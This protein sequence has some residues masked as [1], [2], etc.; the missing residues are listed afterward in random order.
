MTVTAT[1]SRIT[2]AGNGSTTT[3]AVPYY[4]LSN[5]DLALIKTTAAGVQTAL[6]LT[7]DYSVTGAGVLSG[8]SVTLVAAPAATETLIIYRDPSVT[9]TTDYQPNDP[10]PAET[11]ERAL[12]KLTMIGQRLKDLLSRSFRLSDGDTTTASTT[13]PSPQANRLIG[14]NAAGNGLQ[15]VDQQTLA[16]IVGFGTANADVFTGNGSQTAFTLSAN[17]GGQSNLDVSVGGV[18][19]T[20]GT[21]YT[22][23]AGTT[24]TFSTAPPNG[25]SVLVRYAQAL[26]QGTTDSGASTFS[27]AASYGSGTVGK[28]LQDRAIQVAL[29]TAFTPTI[30]GASVAGTPT[31]S[32]QVG[33]Y[34][35]VG[36]LVSFKAC[37][38]I[39]AKTGMSGNL[40]IEGL[41][42]ASSTVGGV[43]PATP[44]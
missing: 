15:N 40:T 17:P 34:S 38:T 1:T 29:S 23:S 19:Q 41:P 22:W 35:K 7:T 13:L 14:W 26:P 39:T 37:V 4:F 12:D 21:H 44:N 30:K 20:P 8:G 28:A 9:Q 25:V 24:L 43:A 11:H 31:Y 18:T 6:T 16:T 36:N 5:S 2:Y 33:S 3:F 32:V 42:V 10:F 27:Q